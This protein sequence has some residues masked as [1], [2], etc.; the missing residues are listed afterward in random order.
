[1]RSFQDPGAAK[2]GRPC[3][4]DFLE[5][6][7][8]AFRAEELANRSRPSTSLVAI[9]LI[10]R[11]L[12]AV[13]GYVGMAVLPF[14]KNLPAVVIFAIATVSLLGS[15]FHDAVHGS[16]HVPGVVAALMERIGSAPV[17]FSPKWWAYKH[18]RLHHRYVSNPE[19]D[20]DIQFGYLG[21]VSRSQPWRAP[22]STQHVHMWFLLPLATLNMIKPSEPWLMRRFGG[23]AGF[24]APPPVWV[25]LVDKYV[26]CALVWLPVFL[27]QSWWGAAGTFL[28]FHLVAGTLVSFITQVQHNTLLADDG[29]DF[30]MRWPLC[31]QVLRT[32]DVGVAQGVWW[33]ICGGAN[34]HVAHHLAPS[35]SFLELPS[36]S[37]RLRFN[38]REV[39]V[40][41]PVHKNMFSAIA[42]HAALIRT[43]AR[44][45]QP[46]G[47]RMWSERQ[48]PESLFGGPRVAPTEHSRVSKGRA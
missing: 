20:P 29:D 46:E 6:R 7:L 8:R 21:R 33:W 25:F 32:T 4:S 39:G 34:F 37:T 16:A 40:E 14:P 11:L 44:R 38:L 24:G 18:V 9:D 28:S 31:E 26:P 35:L 22:H 10:S 36:V 12:P 13:A 42:S 27:S 30:S 19:L 45:P 41:L 3:R 2:A 5:D 47:R 17:G 15:W 43:L 1:M 48:R 23:R